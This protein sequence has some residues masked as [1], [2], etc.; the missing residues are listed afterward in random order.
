MSVIQ[1]GRY[2]FN[3]PGRGPSGQDPMSPTHVVP[4]HVCSHFWLLDRQPSL[5]T[6]PFWSTHMFAGF[7]IVSQ[8]MAEKIHN[9][10]KSQY[11]FFSHLLF[12]ILNKMRWIWFP[13]IGLCLHTKV[14]QSSYLEYDWGIACFIL[15][16]N[17]FSVL[18]IQT[19]RELTISFLKLTLIYTTNRLQYTVSFIMAFNTFVFSKVC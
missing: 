18:W 13:I 12:F 17:Q 3:I 2:I 9:K 19:S 14:K 1:S 4:S 7:L 15:V 10:E 11:N 6:L 5:A 16:C 8:P